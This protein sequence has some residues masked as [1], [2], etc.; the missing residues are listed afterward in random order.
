MVEVLGVLPAV[1][2]LVLVGKAAISGAV[3]KF[4]PL[5]LMS[6]AMLLPPEDA[7]EAAHSSMRPSEKTSPLLCNYLRNNRICDEIYIFGVC[8]N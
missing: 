7:P 2:G 5:A 1:P 3:W 6:S 8:E 4:L